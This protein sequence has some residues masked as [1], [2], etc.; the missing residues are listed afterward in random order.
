[1]N[2]LHPSSPIR[3]AVV[4]DDDLFRALLRTAL[5][6]HPRFRVVA[7][8]QDPERA[9]A[10][11]PAIAPDVVLLDI[12]LGL[13]RKNGVQLGISLRRQLP[14]LGV[15]LLSH[16]REP[17]FLFAV[18][19]ELTHGWSYLLK[20]SVHSLERLERA[21][22]GAAAGL[23][24]MDPELMP[25]GRQTVV[26]GVALSERQYQL[27]HYMAQGHSNKAIAA[28]MH[29]SLKTVENMVGK[30]YSDLGLNSADTERH[31]R[32]EAS[33]L[34]LREMTR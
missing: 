24:T 33:L 15:L 6:A 31:A 14:E 5:S 21:I 23:V 2:D 9:E 4:E 25:L 28:L 13:N 19:S 17:E 20:S 3:L 18:P 16:H 26:N 8:Y 29:L 34:Y 12:D 1:L 30:L 32:V 10:E 7:D 11:L 22:E 27:L